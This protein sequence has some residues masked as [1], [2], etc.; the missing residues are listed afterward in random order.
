MQ[1]N[2]GT[3]VEKVAATLANLGRH[4]VVERVWRRDH[5]VW[6]P[7]PTEIVNRLG[8]LTV[9]EGMRDKVPAL[10]AFAREV[11]GAGF[12]HVVLLGM[13]GS[14]LGAEVLREALGSAAGYP[15][16]IVLDSTLP[17]CVQAV[18]E[19]IDPEHTL[20]LVASK[21]GTTIE[22]VCLSRYF[23]SVVE[24]AVGSQH[25]G[26]N[27]VAMTDA[28][29]PLAVQAEKEEFRRAFLNPSDIGGRYSVLSYF[30]L[31][32]AAL[33][34][35]DAARL[36]E[37]A[38][39]MRRRCAPGIAIEQNAGAWLGAAMGT[40]AQQGRD[41]L[42]LVTSPAVGSFG[43]WVEQLVAESTG[44]EGRGII[45]VVGEPLLEPANYGDDRLFIYLRLEGDDNAETDAAIGSIR[46]SGQPVVVLEMRDRYDLGAQFFLWE[47][48]TSVAGAIL[49]INP[50]IQPDVQSA[51]EATER[52]LGEFVAHGRLPEVR[53]T[54]SFASLLS[55]ART[56][57]YLAIL[58]YIY[59]T[60]ETDR[61]LSNLR[62]KVAAR[63]RMATT[64]GY[65]PRYL[66]STG[67]LHKGGPETGLFLYVTGDHE[68]DLPVPGEPYTFGLL[69]DAQALGD[70][71]AL[72]SQGRPV[73]RIHLERGNL[74][75]ISRLIERLP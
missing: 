18:S 36:L 42:T 45:P 2:L 49:G 47:F 27:F 63:Y 3:Y 40:L 74:A 51:K 61:L 64:L 17:A 34:G 41:K 12:R 66:H 15:E 22:P 73:A 70:L 44:K 16:L 8:W 9:T 55:L 38:E 29:T 23:R 20:F 46:S 71:A 57:R 65:G 1:S 13:G 72:T 11:R 31:V 6:K 24:G 5:T 54:H 37:H 28:E 53:A 59:R 26:G 39:Q 67:Q 56:G 58:A 10:A 32:P 69:A 43:L 30:G 50:F 14:S 48:A 60:A 52:M 35:V 75:A 4:N 25:G 19:T 33:I 62:R 21:S 7:E 68:R